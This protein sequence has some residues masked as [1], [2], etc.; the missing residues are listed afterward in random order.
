MNVKRPTPAAFPRFNMKSAT[1][2]E[3]AHCNDVIGRCS[4]VMWADALRLRTGS[5]W[6]FA[7]CAHLTLFIGDMRMTAH[8]VRAPQ[9]GACM[10]AFE[11]CA[12]H[13]QGHDLLG[14]CA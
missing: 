13:R 8:E 5:A 3:R 2:C 6:Q 11:V 9:L 14:A 7:K 12:P 1:D 4:A 10:A